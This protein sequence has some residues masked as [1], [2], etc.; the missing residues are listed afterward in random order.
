MTKTLSHCCHVSIFFF[1]HEL[2][3]IVREVR[4]SAERIP[5]GSR[6]LFSSGE[7]LSL[8]LFFLPKCQLSTR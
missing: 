6:W 7:G 1:V 4:W 8:C 2:L 5:W 3:H